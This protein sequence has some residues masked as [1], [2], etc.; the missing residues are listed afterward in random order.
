VCVV[1]GGSCPAGDHGFGLVYKFVYIFLPAGKTYLLFGV[2]WDTVAALFCAL[3]VFHVGMSHVVGSRV[4]L[5]KSVNNKS[6][7]GI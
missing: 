4:L 3:A 6:C 1:F 7:P 2:C 5:S